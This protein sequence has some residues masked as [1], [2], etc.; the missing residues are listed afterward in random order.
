MQQPQCN[1]YNRRYGVR[2]CRLLLKLAG[3]EAVVRLEN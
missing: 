1:R 3:M 2:N